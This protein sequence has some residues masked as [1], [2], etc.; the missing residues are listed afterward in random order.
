MLRIDAVFAPDAASA[1]AAVD[2]RW[3]ASDHCPVVARIG[4]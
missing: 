3:R 1:G 2:D 4:L